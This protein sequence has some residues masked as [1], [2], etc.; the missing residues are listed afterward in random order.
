MPIDLERLTGDWTGTN[1]LWLDPNEPADESSATASV[2]LM[3]RG[4]FATVRYTWEHGSHTQEGLLLLR[5]AATPAD[6]DAVWVD[7][8]HMQD[9]A[10]VCQRAEEA[11]AILAVRGSYEAPPGPDWGWTIALFSDAED[12]FRLVM[13]NVSPDGQA[14]L[15]VEA[16]YQR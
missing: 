8:W 6:P 16:A 3:A 9:K 1:K 7:D 5:V 13:H 11:G 10:M 15:A 4:R 2:A 12:A 14:D